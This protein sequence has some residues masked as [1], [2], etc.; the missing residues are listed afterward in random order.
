MLVADERKEEYLAAGH[1]LA[2]SASEVKKPA[3][4]KQVKKEA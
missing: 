3:R 4:S 2:A 1:T